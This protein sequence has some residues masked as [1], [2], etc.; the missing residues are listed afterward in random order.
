MR[1]LF[2]PIALVCLLA[3]ASQAQ[4][5][6]GS[7]ASGLSSWGTATTA[8]ATVAASTY[9]SPANSAQ[10]GARGSFFNTP[11]GTATVTQTFACGS[12][13]ENGFCMMSF[14][15]DFARDMDAAAR[16]TV[17]VD[18]NPVYTADHSANLNGFVPVTF[19][20]GCGLHQL[21]ITASFLSGNALSGWSFWVDNVTAACLP[22]E[23]PTESGTWGSIKATYR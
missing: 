5:T 23:V 7:F 12:S 19:T 21:E 20:A 8:F 18:G 4:V 17:L 6:N 14:D 22:N 11:I 13:F 1:H 16:I 2:A 10:L 3:G 9:G 15:Y